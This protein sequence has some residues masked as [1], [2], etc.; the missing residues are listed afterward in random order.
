MPGGH[1]ITLSPGS[2]MAW[3][4]KG[5][6]HSSNKGGLMERGGWE[7]GCLG[8]LIFSWPPIQLSG[9]DYYQLRCIHGSRQDTIGG[10]VIR[11]VPMYR[12]GH[13]SAPSPR[14]RSD[15]VFT[16]TFMGFSGRKASYSSIEGGGGILR[17]T[18]MW[19]EKEPWRRGRGDESGYR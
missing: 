2:G 14:L 9:P 10:Y 4:S 5:A 7:G 8:V 13:S 19:F 3:M 16:K 17:W 6:D 11:T 1:V 15:T 12:R 18:A